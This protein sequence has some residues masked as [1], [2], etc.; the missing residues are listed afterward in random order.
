MSNLVMNKSANR[1]SFAIFINLNSFEKIKPI[2][3]AGTHYTT[4]SLTIFEKLAITKSPNF[5]EAT[6]FTGD[7]A[8]HNPSASVN[9]RK[10]IRGVFEKIVIPTPLENFVKI[11]VKNQDKYNEL[12]SFIELNHKK[13][14]STQLDQEMKHT[15]NLAN[16]ALQESYQEV[17]KQGL[18]IRVVRNNQIIEE[19]SDG[20]IT[21]LENLTPK[22]QVLSLKLTL[23]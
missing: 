6:F 12:I 22:P 15:T 16:K 7:L 1:K 19:H 10:S 13:I 5:R 17:K 21:V 14:D 9:K 18:S 23:S 8:V 11:E 20:S 2:V 3:T 4:K